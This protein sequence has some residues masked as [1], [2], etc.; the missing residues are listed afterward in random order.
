[1]TKVQRKNISV[2]DYISLKVLSLNKF[3]E[4]PYTDL[5]DVYLLCHSS[6]LLPD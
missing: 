5:T 2:V 3:D 1:M 6:F 4:I